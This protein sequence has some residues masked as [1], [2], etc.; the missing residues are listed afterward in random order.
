VSEFES[1]KRSENTPVIVM[2]RAPIC[3]EEV[4]NHKREAL[5][6]RSW[7]HILAW[8]API[9]L[10][11]VVLVKCGFIM[12]DEDKAKA[13]YCPRHKEARG[14]RELF[15]FSHVIISGVSQPG[16]SCIIIVGVS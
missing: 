4:G 16:L 12:R 15:P 6:L 13:A 2:Q 8:A 7:L 10:A 3:S 11:L 9:G 5:S 1:E 14:K